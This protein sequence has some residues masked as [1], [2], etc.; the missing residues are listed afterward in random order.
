MLEADWRPL[1]PNC[2]DELPRWMADSCRL[3]GGRS[4]VLG[5]DGEPLCQACRTFPRPEFDAVCAG[6]PFSGDLREL[7]HAYKFQG[8]KR[9]ALPLADFMLQALQRDFPGLECDWVVPVPLHRRRLAQRGY[10]QTRKLARI[11]ARRLGAPVFKDVRRV[12]PT[13]PQS[14]LDSDQRRRNLKGAFALRRPDRLRGGRILLVDDVITT[15]TTA[16]ELA[17]LL[18]KESGAERILVLAAA[19]APLRFKGG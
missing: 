8:L 10:D 9:L 4:C 19:R 2:F 17:R 6:G 18:R 14:G 12:K 7:I 3:C 16:Q 13:L 1:C 15:G 5:G 11:L